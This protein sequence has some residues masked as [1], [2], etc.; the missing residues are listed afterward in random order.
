MRLINAPPD[1]IRPLFTIDVVNRVAVIL[2]NSTCAFLFFVRQTRVIDVRSIVIKII[3]MSRL[4]FGDLSHSGGNN[5]GPFTFNPDYDRVTKLSIRDAELTK[6]SL[7][8]RGSIRFNT[9]QFR[10]QRSVE[11]Y[12]SRALN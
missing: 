4:I 11:A 6:Y 3:G 1:V 7:T 9:N 10:V 8:I 2:T 12:I 5:I